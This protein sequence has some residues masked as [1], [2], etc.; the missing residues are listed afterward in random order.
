[1]KRRAWQGGMA[2][3]AV[4]WATARGEPLD[5][6]PPTWAREVAPLIYRHCVECHRPGQAAPFSLLEYGDA[7]RRARFL[8]RVTH[9]RLMP[10]W[11]P[12]EGSAPLEGER[13]LSEEEIAILERWAR[14]GAPA[15][16]LGKAPAPPPA[17][18]GGWRLG[19]PDLVVAMPEPFVVPAGGPDVYRVFVLP[20]DLA[21]IDPAVRAAATIPDSDWLA[22]RAIEV[23]PGN[24]RVL[25]HALV[26]A[27]SSG[28]ARRRAAA[29]PGP[30]YESF[31]GP[32]FSASGFLG[33]YVPGTIPAPLPE[34]IAER[35]P[36]HADLAIQVHYAPT[37]R[38][39]TDRTE[40][41]IY[42]TR[43]PVK[44]VLEWVRLGSF[45]L[46]IPPGVTDHRR[47]DMFTLPVDVFVLSVSPHMHYLG[48]RFAAD[49]IL[50]DGRRAPL[51]RIDRWRFQWQDKYRLA[52]PLYLPRGSRI[53]AEWVFDNSEANPA[54]P[55]RPPQHVRF[56]PNTSDEM[57]EF[58]L[59]VIPVH[60]DDYDALAAAATAHF[61]AQIDALT[62]AQRR[63][64]GFD[65]WQRARGR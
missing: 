2:V 40:V 53:E 61:Q 1:M 52:R 13:R 11:L 50:P 44:R 47:R 32:G 15:G 14:A 46:E 31:G 58:H 20:W 27:D 49:A 60:L 39:E 38:E 3:L 19:P 23:R 56:G 9:D 22:V 25:H 34:G 59:D 63:D 62:P 18:A 45:D 55:H 42:F 48:K 5:E 8:A 41:G 28:E 37:G 17:P 21:K 43:T 12:A 4:A 33:G 29:D 16:D 36:M 65:A 51:L 24:R 7:A 10:P 30:G 6:T 64:F 57:C 35:F 54:N 26:Y